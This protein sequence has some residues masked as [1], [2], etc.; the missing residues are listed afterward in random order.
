MLVKNNMWRNN[1]VEIQKLAE[2]AVTVDILW[3]NKNRVP[4]PGS[5]FTTKDLSFGG[6]SRD[7]MPHLLSLYISL[8]PSWKKENIEISGKNTYWTLEDLVDTEY[9]N[10]NTNGIYDVDD[11]C[12]IKFGNKWTL[13]ANWRTNSREARCINFW[14]P[15]EEVKT[16][17]LGLCPEDAY[18]SMIQ[19]A[20]KKVDKENFWDIQNEIDLWIHERIEKL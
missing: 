3:L 20:V 7:L 8:N 18:Q 5:W 6:V 12:F 10:I 9:G 16:I 2:N 19:E 13:N 17:E 14:R 1:I 4:N 15:N 11:E